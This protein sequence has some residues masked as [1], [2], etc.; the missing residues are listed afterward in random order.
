[1][2]K[3]LTYSNVLQKHDGSIDLYGS[4][5]INECSYFLNGNIIEINKNRYY[6]HK[7]KPRKPIDLSRLSGL[8]E[9]LSENYDDSN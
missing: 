1:M 8:E 7:G 4:E 5:N 9:F 2:I 6:L 3:L